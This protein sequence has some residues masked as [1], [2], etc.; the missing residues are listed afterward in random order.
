MKGLEAN[1]YDRLY[2]DTLI[3][4]IYINLYF[5]NKVYKY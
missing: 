3:K 1:A 5:M 4:D 2:T